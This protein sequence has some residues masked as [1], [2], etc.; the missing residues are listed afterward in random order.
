[1]E[2]A[3]ALV[4][5]KPDPNRDVNLTAHYL[6]MALRHEGIQAT[7]ETAYRVGC[8][9]SQIRNIIACSRLPVE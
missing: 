3:Y 9:P 8:C 7:R 1:M 2:T 4:G 6:Q 5:P